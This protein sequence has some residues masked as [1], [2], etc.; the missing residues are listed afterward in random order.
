M[1]DVAMLAERNV[2]GEVLCSFTD[3]PIYGC[4]HCNGWGW[5]VDEEG[6]ND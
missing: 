6:W 4:A 5:D 2:H 3:I 1:P